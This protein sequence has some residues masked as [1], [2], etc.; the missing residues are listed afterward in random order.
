M[1]VRI[2]LRTRTNIVDL[3][4]QAAL[5]VAAVLAPSA[6]LAFTLCFWSFAAE[7]QLVGAFYVRSGIFSHWQMWFFT[8][9]ILLVSTRLLA[10]YGSANVEVP[11]GRNSN[12][13]NAGGH[14]AKE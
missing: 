4:S 13:H 2:R 3:Q 12:F 5:A 10:S 8:A 11:N 9:L 14:F 1:I 7:L 6:L